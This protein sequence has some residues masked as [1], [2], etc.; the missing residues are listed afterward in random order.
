VGMDVVRRNIES[1]GGVV[2]V[3]NTPECGSLFTVSLPLTLAILDG[4]IVRVGAETYVIPITHIIETLRPRKEQVKRVEGM[5]EVM[6]VRGEVVS[7]VH[8]HR[9]FHIAGAETEASRALVVL[10]ES[11]N[12]VVGVVVD[13]LIGQQQVVIKRLDANANAVRGISGA[14]ILGDGR[15][16]LILEMNELGRMEQVRQRVCDAA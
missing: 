5:N 12:R 9:V 7:L 10:V 2:Q 6:T 14:T 13:E 8:L 4:M 3:T 11:G 15:V 16:S 1:M